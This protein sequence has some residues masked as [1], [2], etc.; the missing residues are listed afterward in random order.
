MPGTTEIRQVERGQP[1][2]DF[3]VTGERLGARQRTIAHL[4]RALFG[5]HVARGTAAHQSEIQGRVRRLGEQR[6]EFLRGRG[7]QLGL[8]CADLRNGLASDRNRVDPGLRRAAVAAQAAD[9]HGEHDDALVSM[10]HLVGSGLADPR[11]AR[12]RDILQKLGQCGHQP[13]GPQTAD[14]FVRGEQ[15]H[16]RAGEAPNVQRSR[17]VH[18]L[19]QKH[20]HVRGAAAINARVVDLQFE[21][22][23][24]P[25]R[26]VNVGNRIHVSGQNQTVR[27]GRAGDR[28]EI[29]F[30]RPGHIGLLQ[31]DPKAMSVQMVCQIG[32]SLDV[33]LMAD[34]IGA[35][36]LGRELVQIAAHRRS[37]SLSI[38][39]GWP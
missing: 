33:A 39:A 29:R 13:L 10:E 14:L 11:Q 5:D 12:P 37:A 7:T 2:P 16:D 30:D 15:Q 25:T 17:G 35:D 38:R 18:A 8:I 19:R 3:A 20:L 34:R 6:G 31:A 36:E 26:L 24:R 22:I 27:L 9:D 21:R 28:Y 1:A 23:A 4:D 32:H